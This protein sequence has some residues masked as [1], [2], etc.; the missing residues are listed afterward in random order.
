MAFDVMGQIGKAKGAVTELGAEKVHETISQI[1]LLLILLQGAGY[2]VSE[3]NIELGMSPIVT[4]DL[5]TS[6]AVSE[7]KLNEILK[8]N[9]DKS[10]LAGI[11]KS[12][13]QAN[14]LRDEVKVETLDLKGV[15]IALQAPPKITLRWKD[16]AAAA[17]S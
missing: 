7:G 3:L 15:T 16:K 9:E 1:N 10:V 8:Q 6:P 12:L 4:V 2:E 5:K 11:L 14:K 13:I 17:Q